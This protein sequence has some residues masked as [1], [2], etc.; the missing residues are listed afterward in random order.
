MY[1]IWLHKIVAD[2]SEYQS[3]PQIS[4]SSLGILFHHVNVFDDCLF[5]MHL[6]IFIILSNLDKVLC[7]VKVISIFINF[8]LFFGDF[9]PNTIIYFIISSKS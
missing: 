1:S 2:P 4:K 7:N 6:D 5:Y 8:S 9:V 3:I